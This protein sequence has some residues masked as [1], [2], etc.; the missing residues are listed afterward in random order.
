MTGQKRALIVVSARLDEEA[1][2]AVRTGRWPR[3][4]F[5][6]LQSALDADVLDY[7]AVE[8]SPWAR[9][10][11]RIAGVPLAQVALAA[12]RARR[13]RAIFTDGEQL[14]IPLGAALRLLP[15]ARRPRHVTIG[16]LLSTPVKRAAFRYIRPQVGIDA[17]LLHATRQIALARRELGS[18]RGR[19][20][21]VPYG[22]DTEF[23][24]PVAGDP[25][26]AGEH[27]GMG[28]AVVSAA[29]LE[30]RDYPTFLRAVAELPVQTVIA[31]GSRWST[32]RNG[33]GEQ[34]PPANVTVTALDYIDLRA[35]YARSALVVVPLHEGDNQAGITTLLEAMAMGKPVIVTRTRGQTDVLR[36]R[37]CDA[38]GPVGAPVGGATAFGVSVEDAGT[39]AG[40]YV[41]PA[42]PAALRAAITYLLAHPDEAA[43][44][45]R[46]GRR[47]VQRHFSLERFVGAVVEAMAGESADT[48]AHMRPANAST[49]SGAA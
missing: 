35:L 6:S 5:F 47:L 19:L 3:K 20:M 41:P 16:H 11:G 36:G 28:D 1:R 49:A 4:D 27:D 34:A 24:Q 29:G 9:A 22:V 40:L 14:G 10:L 44:M 25:V 43:R 45:G 32:H 42:D 33:L 18:R 17:L 37:I 26:G 15:R 48:P 8:R 12:L 23:W 46:A 7:V 31:A 30:Y 38:T 39:E 2:E 21:L 13:Y